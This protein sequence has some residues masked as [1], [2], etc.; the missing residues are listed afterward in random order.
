LNLYIIAGKHLADVL[1]LIHLLKG[2]LTGCN[3]PIPQNDFSGKDGTRDL[4]PGGT[5][6][7]R[8]I[9]QVVTLTIYLPAKHCPFWI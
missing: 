2:E 5:T 9:H 1:R 4:F 6:S 3:P 7:L 8:E